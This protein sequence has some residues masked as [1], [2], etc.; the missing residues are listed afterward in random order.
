MIN[1]QNKYDIYE[2]LINN[3]DVAIDYIDKMCKVYDSPTI[4]KYLR[5][6]VADEF[7]LPLDEICEI[8]SEDIQFDHKD[9]LRVFFNK[10][11]YNDESNKGTLH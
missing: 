10:E 5:K 7:D 1:L 11:L 2:F 9:P 8:I 4:L 6:F 3:M